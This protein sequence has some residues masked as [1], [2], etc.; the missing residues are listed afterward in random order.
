MIV[1]RYIDAELRLEKSIVSVDAFPIKNTDIFSHVD[2]LS[3]LNGSIYSYNVE[4]QTIIYIIY[5][6]LNQYMCSMSPF[7]LML[8]EHV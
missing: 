4:I 3:V 6:S 5:P 8:P 7:T 1:H 2:H